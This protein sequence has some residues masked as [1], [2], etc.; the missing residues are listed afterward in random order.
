M[1]FR[2]NLLFLISFLLLVCLAFPVSRWQSLAADQVLVENGLSQDSKAIT[3][4][5]KVKIKTLIKKIKGQHVQLHFVDRSQPQRV[6]VWANYNLKKMPVT[7]G[8]YFDKDD[9]A[10]PVTL[11]VITPNAHSEILKTQNN[12]YVTDNNRYYSVI[13][14]LKNNNRSDST[15]YFL[16]TGTAQH[17]SESLL[18]HYDLV[19][20]GLDRSQFDDLGRYLKADWRTPRFVNVF[21]HQHR[22]FKWNQ[23]IFAVVILAALLGVDFLLAYP[24]SGRRHMGKVKGRLLSNLISN[25]WAR[26]SLLELVLSIAAFALMNWSV[27]FSNAAIYGLLLA[28]AFICQ[29]A[30]YYFAMVFWL[31]KKRD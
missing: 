24:A 5:R 30:A 9:F 8:R 20:D 23:I 29:A 6:L 26:F 16:T 1:N 31:K 10:S 12:L 18:T 14:T 22:V 4:R 25:R 2:R 13:G 3:P 15:R 17:N 7:E 28:I 11:A 27:F 19:V 21:R